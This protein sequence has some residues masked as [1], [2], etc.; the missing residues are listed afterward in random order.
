MNTELME[1]LNILEKEK[2]I[3]KETLMEAIENSLL[4]AC[5]N[6][7]GKADNVKVNINHETGEFAV[8]AEKTVV[9]KVED[10][11]LEISLS[12]A[13]LMKPDG[14]YYSRLTIK[15]G[16]TFMNSGKPNSENFLSAASNRVASGTS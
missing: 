1:A 9:E 14:P 6:H 5:K 2:D 15:Y 3:S 16:S 13:K 8:F 11:V 10:P 12:D 7:F 4:T